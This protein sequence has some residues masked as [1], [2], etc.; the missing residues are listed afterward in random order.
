[1]KQ[2]YYTV[3]ISLIFLSSCRLHVFKI[4]DLRPKSSRSLKADSISV[5][6]LLQKM[7]EAYGLKTWNSIEAYSIDFEDEFYGFMGKQANPFDAKNI[8]FKLSYIP[9][10]FDGRLDFILNTKARNSWGIQDWNTY[11]LTDSELI[12]K[13]KRDIT[14]WLPTYQY[15]IE[16]PIRIQTATAKSYI[17]DSIIEGKDCSGVIVSWNTLEPQRKIDQYLVWLSKE[18]NRIDKLEYTISEEYRFLTESVL[19]QD[20]KDYN[21]IILPSSLP[22]SSNL[23]KEGQLL[24]T[25]R[26]KTF[27]TNVVSIKD[28]RLGSDLKKDRKK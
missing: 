2:L 6:I 18:T 10:A 24:H 22:V 14:F 25:M 7:E 13:N 4:F 12:F 1:M 11:V 27:T 3:L 9:G 23:L 15:F 17:G 19:Y 16:F 21:G 20:Y 5:T 8:S 26:I 28:L